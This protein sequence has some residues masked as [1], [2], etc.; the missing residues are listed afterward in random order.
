L[1]FLNIIQTNIQLRMTVVASIR[2]L[3][4]RIP[5]VKNDCLVL[6]EPPRSLLILHNSRT[7]KWQMTPIVYRRMD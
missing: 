6:D 2:A 1:V 4:F 5:W 3:A 7:H